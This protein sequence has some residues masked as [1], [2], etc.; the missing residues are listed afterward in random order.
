MMK[1]NARKF[2]AKEK[3]LLRLYS[4]WQETR[5]ED[6]Q[7]RCVKLLR[8]ILALEPTFSLRHEFDRAF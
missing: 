1:G 6:V 3:R 7:E 8:E 2:R 4:L 5:R